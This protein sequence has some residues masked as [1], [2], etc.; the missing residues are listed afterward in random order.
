LTSGLERW[1]LKSV[2]DL[3]HLVFYFST[4]CTHARRFSTRGRDCITRGTPL[5][6]LAQ[7]TR[8]GRLGD[9]ETR[10]GNAEGSR[11]RAG[12]EI[13]GRQKARD[14]QNSKGFFLPPISQISA[15][16]KPEFLAARRRTIHRRLNWADF[17][18]KAQRCKDAR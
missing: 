12:T 11:V 7:G 2:E 4:I 6:R 15:D 1:D 17:N 9:W 3:K 18:A 16:G 10:W 13:F 5:V 8:W 14:T